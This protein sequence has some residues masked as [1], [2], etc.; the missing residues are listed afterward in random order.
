MNVHYQVT[1]KFGFCYAIRTPLEMKDGLPVIF[2][3]HGAGER[4]DGSE[5]EKVEVHGFSHVLTENRE[6]ECILVEPQCPEGTFWVAVIPQ[7][8]T[9]IREIVKA[10]RCDPCRIYLTGMSMG[11]Y[12][13]WYTAMACPELF[14]AIAPCCGGGMPWNAAVLKM[15]LWAFHGALDDA[16]S[17]QETV[18]MVKAVQRTGGTVRLTVHGDCGHDVWDRAYDETL[19]E[20]LLEQRKENLG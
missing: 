5:I 13:T 20:W 6:E 10:C 3:L 19:L 9:F 1:P 7:L 16:V 12:G 14:A 11:G 8:L 18:S 4:G 15:P 2:Q 17:V